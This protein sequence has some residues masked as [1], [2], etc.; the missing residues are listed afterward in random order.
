M[1]IEGARPRCGAVDIAGTLAEISAG[2]GHALAG[3]RRTVI[4]R[5]VLPANSAKT[6]DLDCDS[7]NYRLHPHPNA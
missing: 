1:P 5:W 7:C 3:E 2:S 4:V 6:A